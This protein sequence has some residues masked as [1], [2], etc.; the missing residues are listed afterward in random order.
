MAAST[1]LTDLVFD[2]GTN[3]AS[4]LMACDSYCYV[5]AE[6]NGPNDSYEYNPYRIIEI[7]LQTSSTGAYLDVD[8][9]PADSD[10]SLDWNINNANNSTPDTSTG[11]PFFYRIMNVATTK[12][13]RRH[14]SQLKTLTGIKLVVAA[15]VAAE[16]TNPA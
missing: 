7:V 4:P 8:G 15:E 16:W 1:A 6:Y 12:V 2:T 13:I 10:A 9:D 11:F 14:E 3:T 5:A